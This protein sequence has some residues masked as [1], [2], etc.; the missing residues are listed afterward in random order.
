M[1]NW[2]LYLYSFYAI[3]TFALFGWMLSLMTNKVSHVDSMWSLF[4]ILAGYSVALLNYD[5]SPRILIVLGL[6][7]LWGVRLSVHIS[8]RNIAHED[9]RYM[10][11]RNNNEPNFWLKSLYIV[12]G[13]QAVLA[14]V[15]SLSIYG[16]L[17]GQAPLNALDYLGL[18]LVLFG[19]YWEVL[20]D[21]QLQQFKADP[22]NAKRVLDTGLWRYSR[23]PN[24]FGE[25]CVWWGFYLFALAAGAWWAIVSP[26]LMTYLLL[27]ISG[28]RLLEST[29]TERR[30]DYIKYIQNTNAFVPG[31]PK[32][33]K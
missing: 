27:N 5:S 21:W 23:H 32:N 2:S 12:F 10:A 19:L 18:A 31:L 4:F 7:S 28:V 26:V 20:A 9:P 8:W 6:L 22:A 29:I 15:I 25:C 24:Y 17:D 3:G 16:A 33:A 30:P 11:I 1:F 13:L 14:W